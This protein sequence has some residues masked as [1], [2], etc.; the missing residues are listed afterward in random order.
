MKTQTNPLNLFTTKVIRICL[1]NYCNS[2]IFLLL[3]SL[4]PSNVNANCDLSTLGVPGIYTITPV[5]A[6]FTACTDTLTIPS[7]YTLDLDSGTAF[8]VGISTL[9]VESGGIINVDFD[10]IFPSTLLTLILK[11][12][13]GDGGVPSGTLDFDGNETLTISSFTQLIIENTVTLTGD[14]GS[15]IIGSC[16]Q[17]VLIFIDL[18]PYA[19]CQNPNGQGVCFSFDQVIQAGGSPVFETDVDVSGSSSA[20]DNIACV[21]SPFPLSATVSVQGSGN[22]FTNDPSFTWAQMSGPGTLTFSNDTISNPTVTAD[23]AGI[24]IVRVTAIQNL[25]INNCVSDIDITLINDIEITILPNI[26]ATVSGDAPVCQFAIPE[27][28]FTITNTQGDSIIVYYNING[29]AA[30]NIAVSASSA[31][32]VFQST[33]VA[34]TFVI[35]LDSARYAIDPACTSLLSEKDTIIINPEPIISGIFNSCIGL[36]SQLTATPTGGSWFSLNT[37]I[38]TVDVNGLV[39]GVALGMTGIEY[40]SLD[41]CKDTI[42]FDIN[43]NGILSLDCPNNIVENNDAD[44]CTS[45]ISIPTVVFGNPCSPSNLSWHADGATI[46]GT[47]F[48]ESGQPNTQVFNV[49]ITTVYLKATDDNSGEENCNFTVTVIDNRQPTI[50]VCPIARDLTGCNQS[51]I[52]GPIFSSSPVLSSYAIFS[53]ANNQGDASDN[54]SLDSVY[55]LDIVTSAPNECPIIVSRTWTLKDS[56]NNDVNCV[57]TLSITPPTIIVTEAAST[58]VAACQTQAQIETAFQN[59]GAEFFVSGGCSPSISIDPAIPTAPDSCGG[60]TIVTWTVSNGCYATST[61]ID[62]FTVME[63]TAVSVTEATTVEE[64]SCQTQDQINTAFASWLGTFSVSGGCNATFSTNPATPTAPDSCGGMTIVTWTVTADHCY[65]STTHVDTFTVVDATSIS[66]TEASSVEENSCQT[67]TAIN[68]AFASWL[69]TF[70]VSGGCNA[71]FSTNP[72][73]PSA[74]DSCGGMT[75]VTWTVTADHCYNSTTHLDTFTVIDATAVSVTEA[76]TVEE[77][78]CQTQDQINTAFASWLGTF[79][80]SGGCNATFS[81]NPATPTAPD[82]CGGMT[83][84]IWTVSADHCYNST[85]HVDTFTITD[86]TTVS[87]TEAGTVQENSCQTQDQINTAFASWLGT[88]SVSGGCNAAFSTNPASPVAPDSC[89][90]MTIVTWTVSADHC[91]NSTTHV[92]TFTVTDATTVSVTEAS[93]VQENSCQTQDQINTAF[94]SWLGTFSV[95]GGCNAAFSTNPATPTA[96]DSCG[97]MTI[98]TWTVSADHCYNSTTHVDTFTVVDATT[99]SV[100]EASSVQENSCQTQDQ[101]NTA[102]ASWLGTFSVSGGC[103]A[104]FSTNPATPTAPDSCGGMTIVTWTVSADHCYNST[105]HVDTFTVTDATTVSVTEAGTVQE[106]SCQTQDQINTAFASWLG[107]FSVSGGCNAAFSTNPATPT[108]PDSCGGMTIVTWTVTADHCYNSTTHVDT[109]T[110]VD[111]TTV[112]VTEASSVQE[113][114]CQTQIAINSAF[115]SWL[116]TFSVSGG[117]N[118]AFSTNPATPTAPDSCG[119][120]T[121]VT[122]TVTA[123]HCYNSTTHVDTFSVVDAITV[124]VTEASSVQENSCQT[125][126][127]INTA[128]ASWLGTFSVSGGCNAAFSTIPATPTAPDSCGGMT[129]VT[130]TV[131]ADHCYNS[132]THVDTFT[133]TDATTVSVTEAGTVEENSCQTQDQINTAFA[134]WL[135]TFSV[136]G[137]CNAAFSTNPASPVAPDSCG[138]M[139]IVTWTVSADHCYNST[140]HVDTFTV[141]DATTV[142]VTEASSVQENSCQTQDQINTAFAS[143]LGTFS[144]SGGCNAAFSTNPATPVAPDSCGGMTIVKWTVSADHC[145]NSTTHV[146]TFTVTDATPVSVTEAGTTEENSCQTQDQ[147]NTAF[148]SWLGTF[149]VSGGCN[150]AF[151][152]NPASPVAPDSCGGMTIVTWTV[153]ADHCYNSTT[154]VDTFTVTDA[155]TAFCYRSWYHG[156]KLLSNSRLK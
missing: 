40:T 145:Y 97:G 63:A 13:D 95:S 81:T 49:G 57:Q 150:A 65:N 76:T 58:S 125:Q 137:G 108:A 48:S 127:Q 100:T 140:T 21:D 86:A 156:R 122:W 33:A 141:V 154:H 8:P 98:V 130:W 26:S 104:A 102:F 93:S 155:T 18:N 27:P 133:V 16:S 39:T 3:L 1:T 73:T 116:A 17:Q 12:P 121:I 37:A 55:Y 103:N 132:T 30:Q 88:F 28:K 50:S 46:I 109:F 83:I 131:T 123:D 67:Q 147:I 2:V 126:D 152:T 10:Y 90:G 139:T 44:N 107:T 47:N 79:N 92:D 146:D 41:G 14:T 87:V 22:Q 135:G 31:A 138:G 114:S 20:D 117:C 59:W 148:A 56:S 96:P 5:S 142:S 80:V 25:S 23:S 110:V 113:S 153:S 64:N 99:V 149:S 19:G 119:G 129:I 118:A 128:F 75:I 151:S 29:G 11:D 32:D 53:D 15:A 134:S 143:W 51:V 68:S 101:I 52:T 106:N 24:Y 77:N 38:A 120:M 54:C 112:S 71:A 69:G 78:S 136:S 4:Y 85:T 91:Y 144:V 94:A 7:G 82:S 6:S 9:I 70:S 36:T 43:N 89:G 66:V 60:M 84:V 61:H 45:S 35:T 72:V 34:D 62:T 111:A 42:I 105:T 124:S 74:P 115:A